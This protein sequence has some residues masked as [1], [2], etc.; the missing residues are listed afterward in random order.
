MG[1]CMFR[2]L[3]HQRI[4]KLLA[5]LN[6]DFL[7]R[8]GCYF[9][10]GTAIVLAL[11]EYRESID[12]DF[13]CSSTDGYRAL[14]NTITSA[15]L[16]N[17]L[18]QPIELAREVR[19]DRYGIR[20]FVQVDGIPI[21]FEIVS[22][23]RIDI[24]G[25]IDPVL[26]IPTLSRQDMYAEKLLANADRHNDA[27]VASRDAIDLAMLIK[28][29]GPIPQEAWTKARQAYGQS[30]DTSYA[31]AIEL[32]SNQAYLASCLEK[33][34]MEASLVGCVSELLRRG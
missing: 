5:A 7:F 22:E 26:G 15:S 2:R 31:K 14:R 20:T 10:G 34:Q 18:A 29:W 3:H 13:L 1:F 21:K 16:G 23:G 9:G 6:A 30:I 33:M 11:N 19:A 12:V 8:S 28:H 17:I 27:S 32:T 24:T 25:T 4:A